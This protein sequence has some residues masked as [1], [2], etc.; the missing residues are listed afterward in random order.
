MN[1]L[2]LCGAVVLLAVSPATVSFPVTFDQVVTLAI[3]LC[4]V[5]AANAFLL[6]FSLRPL[7]ELTEL[8]RDVDLLVPG[9]RLKPFGAAELRDL[10][11]SFNQMLNRLEAE[12]RQ[13]STR[14]LG[15][16][17]AERRR[18]AIELHDEVGQGLTALLL[19]VKSILANAPPGLRPQLTELQ[20]IAR[21]TLDEVRQ[22]ARQLRPTTLDDLG[23]GFSLHSLVDVVARTT[24]VEFQ[25]RIETELPPFVEGGDVALFRIAQE[26]LTNVM[27]HADATRVEVELAHAAGS[28]RLEVRDDGRGMI[29]AAGADS[30][31]IRGMR[32]RVLAVGGTVQVDSRPGGGT[33]VV[34]TVPVLDD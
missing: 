10:A 3:G 18:L 22:M 34:A 31:G 32:E 23:L 1:A 6:R 19:Q 30:G 15:R 12:R 13:S 7:R 8:M 2:L 27:R 33:A 11:Q 29:Y 25:R 26:A 21:G 16:V 9:S 17:E 4:V 24:G 5:L 14:T 28:V 20:E